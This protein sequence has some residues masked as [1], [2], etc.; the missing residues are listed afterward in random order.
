[1]TMSQVNVGEL[2]VNKLGDCDSIQ[3]EGLRAVVKKTQ[4]R[5]DILVLEVAYAH[6]GVAADE[7]LTSSRLT[8]V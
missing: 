5:Q 4:G 7:I 3:H 2:G 6:K 8:R 1:M